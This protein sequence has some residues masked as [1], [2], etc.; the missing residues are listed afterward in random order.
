MG[1]S[2]I[3]NDKDELTDIRELIDREM[4]PKV[5]TST[6]A[7][8]LR[9]TSGPNEKEKP[10][11]KSVFFTKIK[12]TEG[13]YDWT[14]MIDSFGGNYN[15]FMMAMCDVTAKDSVFIYGPTMASTNNANLIISA[16]LG[17]AS[18]NIKL[19]IPHVRGIGSAY[20]LSYAREI[21]Y[22]PYDVFIG[23]MDEISVGGGLWDAKSSLNMHN[24]KFEDM[25]D[26][27]RLVGLI[28]D[29]EHTHLLEKQG[30]ILVY[31]SDLMARYKQYN[32][33]RSK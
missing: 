11:P 5:S 22:S 8:T 32:A 10:P 13:S 19:A 1:V 20:I 25:L 30:Q 28:T 12:N 17:C 2:L 7:L 26:R 15:D 14:F 18:K 24:L 31:G 29:N 33:A 16:M 6:E 21:V 4:D 9:P 23:V 27:L 3:F